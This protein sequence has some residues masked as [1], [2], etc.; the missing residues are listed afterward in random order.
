MLLWVCVPSLPVP[1]RLLPRQVV[2]RLQLSELQVMHLRIANTE[3]VRLARA[4]SQVRGMEGGR[5]G[6]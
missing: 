1:P 5:K 4:T 2:D 3:F 6:R